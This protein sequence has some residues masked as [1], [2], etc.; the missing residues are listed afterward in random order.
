M[1]KLIQVDKRDNVAIPAENLPKGSVTWENLTILEDIPQGHKIALTDLA[2]GDKVIRYGVTL[3]FL[4]TD[5]SKGSLITEHMLTLPEPPALDS[6]AAGTGPYPDLPEAPLKDFEGYDVPGG[7][8][9]GTRNILGIM[10]TVQ[11]VSGVLDTAVKKM[12]EELLPK[13]PHVDDIVALNHAYGCGVAI[14][15]R[16]SHI[17]ITA[18]RSII[19]NPNFGGEIM[20]VGLGCEKLTPD[21]LLEPEENNPENVIILQDHKGFRAMTDALLK[22]AESKLERL[23]RRR[24][25]ILPLNRLCIGMQCGGSDAFS[26]IT[27]NPAAGYA[28]DLL[29]QAGATVLFSEVTEVRDGVHMLAARC[30][31][32][33]TVKKLA[34]EMAWYDEYLKDGGA[35]R[36]ANPTPGNKK[37]GLANIMEKAMGS[38]AKS[39]TASIAEVLSPGERPSRKGLIFAATPASDLVC[40]AMQFASGIT[41]QVFMTGRGTPY[42]LAAAP[43]IKVSSRTDL[44]DMWYDLIDVDAGLIASGKETI[45]ETGLRLF[46]KIIDVASGRDKPWTEKYGLHNFLC[47]FNPAPIT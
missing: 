8:Y 42:G 19:R 37:G 44:Q 31:D 17:P 34:K 35:D 13:Y 46:H 29:V 24:R 4:N 12:K 32:D 25:S 47:V 10:T 28:S 3:G 23:N 20:V 16:E 41:L 30:T 27:A 22:M 38:I 1:I 9:A 11:C 36:S 6:L 39:G 43:V 7:G 2:K 5:V 45:E 26:G 15:A 21:M 33:D 18:L 14:N 40:G